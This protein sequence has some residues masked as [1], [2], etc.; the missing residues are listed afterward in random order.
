MFMNKGN[1]LNT[2]EQNGLEGC[3][4]KKILEIKLNNRNKIKK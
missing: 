4:R 1:R 3:Y 2:G